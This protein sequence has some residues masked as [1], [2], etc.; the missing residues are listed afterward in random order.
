MCNKD[1]SLLLLFLFV[2][3]KED[4]QTKMGKGRPIQKERRRR[5][6]KREGSFRLPQNPKSFVCS[7]P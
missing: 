7:K 4:L 6:Q 3:D 5:R 1:D 2:V